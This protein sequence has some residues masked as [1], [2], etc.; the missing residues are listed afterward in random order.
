MLNVAEKRATRRLERL[1]A[2]T[3]KR[4]DRIAAASGCADVTSADMVD[5]TAAATAARN[6][7]YVQRRRYHQLLRASFKQY[8]LRA[9][10]A[11][12]GL[13]KDL[14]KTFDQL[15]GRGKPPVSLNITVNEFGRYFHDK[16]A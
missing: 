3:A 11:N 10:E 6:Q 13:S 14:W 16:V 15:M 8:W 9:V 12:Q 7:W 1:S 2:A 4:T 5:A